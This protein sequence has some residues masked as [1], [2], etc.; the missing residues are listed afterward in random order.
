VIW[1]IDPWIL[2]GL[3]CL[4]VGVAMMLAAVDWNNRG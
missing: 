1:E 2:F 4:I 3:I